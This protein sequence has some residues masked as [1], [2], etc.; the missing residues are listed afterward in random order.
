MRPLYLLRGNALPENFSRR[1]PFRQILTAAIAA[2]SSVHFTPIDIP[3]G[4][5]CRLRADKLNHDWLAALRGLLQY[6]LHY[7]G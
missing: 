4:Y 2:S 1:F 6:I 7:V 5:A 3:A